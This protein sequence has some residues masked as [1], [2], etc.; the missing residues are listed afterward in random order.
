[1][2][3]GTKGRYVSLF[4]EGSS[5]LRIQSAIVATLRTTSGAYRYKLTVPIPQNLQEPA[6]G[7]RVAI[8][9][10]TV[11]VD[12][13]RRRVK[14]KTRGYLETSSCPK[15]GWTFKGVFTYADG[16]TTTET[17]RVRCRK[18]S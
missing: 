7:V 11:T 6:P 18:S 10:F 12:R 16:R 1:M 9:D 17:D 5:P 4:V 13:V 2:A 15:G 3:N 14:G 8:S